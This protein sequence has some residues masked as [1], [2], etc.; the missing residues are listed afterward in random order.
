MRLHQVRM[1][2]LQKA[3]AGTVHELRRFEHRVADPDLRVMNDSLGRSRAEYFS[4]SKA[5]FRKAMTFSTPLGCSD[6]V[7]RPN[8]AGA[9]ARRAIRRNVPMIPK[10][11]FTQPSAISIRLVGELIQNGRSGS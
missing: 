7:T 2:K 8:P 4:V 3:W 5:C 6:K 1:R 10:A 9:V 11:S